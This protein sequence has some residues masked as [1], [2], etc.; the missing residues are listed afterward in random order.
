M[1]YIGDPFQDS[2]SDKFVA[3]YIERGPISLEKLSIQDDLITYTTKDEVAHEFDAV[4]F[5]ALLSSHIPKPYECMTRYYGWY[6]CRSRGER[7]KRSPVQDSPLPAPEPT[8]RPSLT[9]AQCMKRVYE[10]NPLACPKCKGS[11][12]IVAF[13]QNEAEISKIMGHLGIPKFKPPP[14]L[15]MAPTETDEPF[16]STQH[17]E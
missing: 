15:P 11:M 4:E 13:L 1:N 3:R 5:L 16:D 6:S 12:R 2:E 7:A 14:K 10:I 8:R 17:W 9:W